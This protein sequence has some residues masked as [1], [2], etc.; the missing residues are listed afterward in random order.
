MRK[1][2]L[3]ALF[4][5]FIAVTVLIVSQ[6]FTGSESQEILNVPS[7]G[8]ATATP[9]ATGT[10]NT[11]EATATPE[12]TQ[13]PVTRPNV[14]Y[15]RFYSLSSKYE[16]AWS[17]F[18]MESLEVIKDTTCFYTKADEQGLDLYLTFNLGYIQG[19]EVKILDLLKA[20]GLKATFFM[21]ANFIKLNQGAGDE[22][23]NILK[24]I[25]N[26]GHVLGVRGT[27]ITASMTPEQICDTLWTME[28]TYQ[29]LTDNTQRMTYFRPDQQKISEKDI[30]IAEAM[31]YKVAL[32]SRT[33]V[34]ETNN[35]L[36]TMIDSLADGMIFSM[37][38]SEQMYTA[39]TSFIP[40]ATGQG[41][42]FKT[43][44]Q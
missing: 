12:P 3:I 15:T 13:G 22:A 44:D 28:E 33:F 38:T 10:Q 39:L 25:V 30:A 16:Q 14:D 11:P 41:Y 35:L 2:H 37:D 43:L 34:G 23:E 18:D 20:N 42:S 32:W 40:Q 31:G 5:L 4:I 27:F 29:G 1:S 36:N 9:T 21:P 6:A 8:P 26:E 19:T 7:K 17:S 24:R